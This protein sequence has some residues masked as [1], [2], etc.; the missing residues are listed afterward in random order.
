MPFEESRE[1]WPRLQCGRGLGGMSAD[2]EPNLTRAAYESLSQVPPFERAK[3]V[4]DETPLLRPVSSANEQQ[5]EPPADEDE[6]QLLELLDKLKA[7]SYSA[8]DRSAFAIGWRRC[9]L[10][11][12]HPPNSLWLRHRTTWKRSACSCARSQMYAEAG[13]LYCVVRL[14]RVLRVS[15]ATRAD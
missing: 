15:P 4:L 2:A 7:L 12:D 5:I 11:Q 8:W 1:V 14:V 10:I 6:R 13:Q 9:C 3:L